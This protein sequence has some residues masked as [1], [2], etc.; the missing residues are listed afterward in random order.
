VEIE[1][2]FMT[3]FNYKLEGENLAEI[4]ENI[5]P[6]WGDK[7]AIPRPIL[8]LCRKDVLVMEYLHGL[9]LEDG[10]RRM[11]RLLAHHLGIS[12]DSLLQQHQLLL[13]SGQ[14]KSPTS[15]KFKINLLKATI[16][17]YDYLSNSIR[18][19]YNY[20]IGIVLKKKSINGLNYL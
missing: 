12:F 1:K 2:Q 9:K 18:F 15:E 11:Y 20:S 8:D 16:R 3:E 10:I 17:M 19:L 6:K 13:R 4:Y 7:V 14:L 5:N